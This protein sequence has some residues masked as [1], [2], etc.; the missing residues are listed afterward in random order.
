MSESL[1][2][3]LISLGILV[4]LVLSLVVWKQPDH[5]QARRWTA[6]AL[7]VSFL[8]F[9]LAS[10]AVARVPEARL[11][12]P[13]WHW[14]I[15]DALNAIPLSLFTALALGVAV[16]A[17]KRKLTA[18]WLAGLLW[19]S[20]TTSA[21]YAANNLV[22]FVLGWA[23]SLAPFLVTQ[24][25]VRPAFSAG[26]KAAT[27]AILVTGKR[28]LP[29]LAQ[30]V[31]VTSLV[32]LCIGVALLV[33]AAPQASWHEALSLSLVRS[34]DTQL[35]FV[36]FAFL[37]VA[38]VLRKGMFP[39][40][41]WVVTAFE[42]GSLL[43]MTLLVNGHLGAFLVARI[44]LP[45]L[46]DVA[47][48][49]W[50][51]FS[52]LGLLTAA[53]AALLALVTN[54]ARRLF[55]LVAISQSAFLL[56]GL[57]SNTP[58]GI[59]GSL[60]LWQVVAVS[61]TMLA[62]VYVGLEARLGATLENN[63]FLGLAVGAPRLAVFFA[64]GGLALVGL[65]LTLGFPAEDLLLQGTLAANPYLGVVL[66]VVTALNAFSV[67]R[68]FARLFLGRPIAAAHDLT[69]ALPRERWVL[70]AAL[71]FLVLGGLFP[72]PLIRLPALAAEHI[73]KRVSGAAHSTSLIPP[74]HN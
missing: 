63:G 72:A 61:T 4:P 5:E 6:G 25:F 10:L 26:P 27:D 41:S 33:Y 68:L 14:F 22:I 15:V 44:V 16:F 73:V 23:G 69:D 32:S 45:L 74:A 36:A 2:F 47:H 52:N 46:P 21:A 1:F 64:V 37:M 67:V 70:A 60:V 28:A 40:H 49:A 35:L 51:L 18:P 7:G 42:Q 24:A 54:K 19:L 65:P 11:T 39:A 3:P 62:A 55:A 48:N 30:F 71:L 38:V 57:E 20:A 43:P 17:P 8:A 66:P 59:A 56:T 53:Y 12:D 31:L 58:I 50:P 34:G 29:R 13:L 9:L